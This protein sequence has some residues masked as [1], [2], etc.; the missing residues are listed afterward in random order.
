M[1]SES[2][3]KMN[4]ILCIQNAEILV[5]QFEISR[6]VDQRVT[7]HT[8]C[9]YCVLEYLKHEIKWIAGTAGDWEC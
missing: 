7:G 8:W 9:F 3:A 2:D 4:R 5:S 1:Q 6:N